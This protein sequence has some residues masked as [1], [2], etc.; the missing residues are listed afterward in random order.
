[1][2]HRN[3]N[4]RPVSDLISSI[5]NAIP[6]NPGNKDFNTLPK[7]ARKKVLH[8]MI[9]DGFGGIEQA[10]LDYT[11]ALQT[12]CNVLTV[13]NS[14]AGML[15]KFAN[16]A[17]QMVLLDYNFNFWH[18]VKSA[19][20]L[21]DLIHR[22]EPEV[23]IAHG[24]HALVVGRLALILYQKPLA[25]IPV[26]HTMYTSCISAWLW[27]IYSTKII[28]VNK[29][30]AGRTRSKGICIYNVTNLPSSQC[31]SYNEQAKLGRIKYNGKNKAQKVIRIGFLGRL[32]KSKGVQYLIRALGVLT[33]RMGMDC[34]L[35]IGGDGKYAKVLK[36]HIFWH[37]LTDR[38]ELLGLIHDKDEFFSNLDVFCL[39]SVQ[40][41]FGIVLL[42]AMVR[43]VPVIASNID[44][45][46][47][48][49]KHEVNGLLF[50]VGDHYGIAH[51]IGYIIHNPEAR[52]KFVTNAYNDCLQK[53]CMT[54]LI[55]DLERVLSNVT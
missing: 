41:A 26:R 39:P 32:V 18:R 10:F 14:K 53:F 54:R 8:L 1:M 16:A 55:N 28:G 20:Q 11:Y 43:K 52:N 45:I 49:I 2:V 34:R 12:F 21:L 17:D 35:V 48:I 36:K 15:E 6:Y 27:S 31:P 22:F 42:E 38:V 46:A 44:G 9:N 29:S 40:E 7:K 13:V 3:H 25:F 37:N 47:D 24:K 33:M 51:A 4:K 23:I 50:K 5:P 19:K 30:I